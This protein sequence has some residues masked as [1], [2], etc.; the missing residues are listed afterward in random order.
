[1]KQRIRHALSILLVCAMALSLLP[2]SVWAVGD[3]T[4]S[5]KRTDKI[6]FNDGGTHTAVL[7]DLTVDRCDLSANNGSAMEISGGTH[8]TLQLRGT[9]QLRGDQNSP[10]ILV[11]AGSTLTIEGAGALIAQAGAAEAEL[12]AAG[13]G[14][15]YNQAAFGDITIR[16]GAITASGIGG[17]A[18]IGGGCLPGGGTQTGDITIS[19][20][21]VKAV[22]G[23]APNGA[24]AGTGIGAGEMAGYGGT[25]TI[26]GGVV[27]AE[28]GR[29]NVVSIGGGG[30]VAGNA[31][32][33]TFSTGAHGSAVIAAPHGI[34]ARG[35]AKDWDGIFCSYG[36]NE[37][38]AVMKGDAVVLSGSGII[39]VWGDPVL[40]YDLTVSNG[41]NLQILKDSEGVHGAAALTMGE[42]STL[43]NNGSITLGT[44]ETD[45][46][47]LILKGGVEKTAGS[48]TL[49]VT[50]PAVVKVP[51]TDGL[52]SVNPE[53]TVYNGRKQEPA[54]TAAF[55]QW[56][57]THVFEAGSDYT[58]ETAPDAEYKNAADYAITLR[59]DG[60]GDL[61][62]GTVKTAY[63]VKQAQ[64]SLGLNKAWSIQQG[65]QGL[66]GK[67][68]KPNLAVASSVQADLST[69]KAGELKWYTDS[70]RST[71]VTDEYL[72]NISQN[73]TIYGRYTHSDPN[74][75]SPKDVELMLVVTNDPVPDVTISGSSVKQGYLVKTYGDEEEKLSVSIKVNG[76]EQQLHSGVTWESNNDK[77]VTVK[78]DGTVSLVGAGTAKITV[79]VAASNKNPK[80]AQAKAEIRV[81]VQPKPVSV[82]NQ[83]IRI[84]DRAYDGT[85]N[86]Q[87]DARLTAGAILNQDDAVLQATG[88]LSDANAGV[89]KPVA[90]AYRLVG[91]DIKNYSL[92][93]GNPGTV[94]ISKASAEAVPGQLT[95]KNNL[96]ETYTFQMTALNPVLPDGQVLGNPVEYKVGAPDFTGGQ[97]KYEGQIRTSTMLGTMLEIDL[98]QTAGSAGK[99]CEIPVTI[100]SRNFQD[101][102]TVIVLTAE[103]S[104]RG[105]TGG[106]TAQADYT[107]HYVTNGGKRLSDETKHTKWTKDD[108][109]L[110]TPV[111]EGYTFEGWYTDQDLTKPVAGDVKVSKASVTLYAKWSGEKTGPDGTGVSRWLETQRHNAYLSGYPD[112]SFHPDQSMTRAEVAQMFCS[113]LGNKN[114]TAA[115]SFADVPA[116]AWYA[117]A[118]GTLAGLDKLGGYPDGTFRPDAPITRA[119]FAAIALAFAKESAGASCSYADVK[120]G[121]WYYP[122][123]AQ[124]TAYG[125]IGGYPDGSF[126][127]G[128]S[129][130]RAEVAVIVNN[131]L[132]RGA[133][134]NFIQGHT[135]E[136]V[137]FADLSKRHWAYYTIMEAANAH[138]H[139]ESAGQETWK[140]AT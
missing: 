134:K 65:T 42:S 103:G 111:R 24:S 9:N 119:E 52:V 98:K 78:P 70:G 6:V 51:L 96:A 74:F 11:E 82:D 104:D 54:V 25:I 80:Y 56:N 73:T 89:N 20:G 17:G 110:P 139:E 106:T 117:K 28:S 1:M 55:D 113:L 57:Y 58:Q 75:V 99:V 50:Q 92:A 100:T 45:A 135:G 97:R 13:I 126:Q 49:T 69:L 115:K 60:T 116:Q 4:Y 86:V 32:H 132:G 129:I 108:K 138:A 47:A 127:P 31:A 123:V 37:N 67:L 83:S 90:I 62:P 18:G 93:L 68:P 12:G 136:I 91:K 81:V 71:E 15:G 14:G 112:G 84:A 102:H 7:E 95:I 125:W 21:W 19:G 39:Q 128:S 77:V 27:Y 131:M 94:T 3:E 121:A 118:V 30:S 109:A 63:K 26:S 87:V 114:V 48:G 44:G 53:Q 130:T 88:T 85:K 36:S 76:Q 133:D 34:G 10:A 64:Y 105:H 61:L 41:A 101:I 46:S 120:A 59:A 16:G 5:G 33:G 22:G 122:Y 107:L 137:R 35:N 8:V 66:L 43:T 79:T 23:H 38:T 72:K 124:A 40:E 2:V 140:S 29:E